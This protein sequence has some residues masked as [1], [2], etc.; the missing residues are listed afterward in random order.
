MR[1]HW[2]FTILLPV[3][4]LASAGCATRDWVRDLVGK[5]DAEIDQRFVG[6]EKRV[7]EDAERIEGLGSRL[8]TV[9]TSLTQ[10]A[11]LSRSAQTQSE[12]AASPFTM[13]CWNS[14]KR[15]PVA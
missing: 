1:P 4:V 2:T 13:L 5:K 10:T 3:A 14:L 12:G 11:Q 9:K 8:Q 7:A 15:H 6:V